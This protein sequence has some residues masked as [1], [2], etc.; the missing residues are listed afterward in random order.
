MVARMRM[1]RWML[2]VLRVIFV[3][4]AAWIAFSWLAPSGR[5]WIALVVALGLVA[6]WIG[7][8]W[9]VVRRRRAE[10]A[11]ADRWASA[12]FDPPRRAEAMVEIRAELARAD[13]K[14]DAYAR[15]A[16]VLA[17]MLEADGDTAG[18][19]AVLD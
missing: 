13:R 6:G 4:V 15:I 1:R 7:F 2:L 19:R 10:E 16:L 9:L 3:G 5:G 12:L 18:A 14:T 8:R 17:E 11:R